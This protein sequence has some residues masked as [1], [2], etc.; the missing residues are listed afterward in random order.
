[1]STIT[2]HVRL[3]VCLIRH[4]LL[5]KFFFRFYDFLWSFS[6]KSGIF[7]IYVLWCVDKFSMIF[8][9]AVCSIK[10]LCNC[11]L[12]VKLVVTITGN[13]SHSVNKNN[14]VINNN[15]VIKINIINIDICWYLV[16]VG[17]FEFLIF[18]TTIVV[19]KLWKPHTH[20]WKGI[21]EFLEF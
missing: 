7:R 12:V 15:N 9:L 14:S 4:L 10:T 13:R 20:N 3:F 1:M 17:H 11:T 21:H 5:K 6:K 16:E 2:F 18:I 8:I 19:S